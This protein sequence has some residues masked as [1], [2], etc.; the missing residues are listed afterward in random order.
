MLLLKKEEIQQVFSMRDAI[1]ADKNCYKYFSEGK[2]VVPLRTNIPAPA[3]DG[4]FLFMPAYI[5]DM[6]AAAVKV[7]D[8]FPR[9]A[10]K[11][12]PTT[13]G[14]VILID[15][16]TGEVISVMDGTYITALRTGAASG[17]AFDLWGLEDAKI[18]ALIGTGSQAECQLE[19]M[20]A[21]R[22]LE[23]V[24]VSARN[25]EKTKAFV[26]KMNVKFAHYGTKIIAVATSDEAIEHADLVTTVTV[27]EAP[28]FDADKIKKGA[29][30]SCV[31]SYTPVM[32]EMDPKLLNY[33]SKIYFDSK[34]AVLSESGDILKPLEAGTVKEEDF[35][36]DIGEYMLG[37]IP[38]RENEEE[39]IVFKNVGIG[40]LD[41]V[42]AAEI[43]K[44]AVAAGVGLEWK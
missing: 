1:E 19:A 37:Q 28:V 43:Y 12:I 14:Q 31:G 4:A 22:N 39:I 6:K 35:T 32:Q 5:E 44:K 38:G 36:G 7:V 20:L 29:V 25:F 17:A 21:A 40:A 41:L 11:G 13:V 16:T 2:A 26:E 23:E 3:E 24:R 10:K 33:A 42:T 34:D 15:G 8:V 18:G 27:A 30:V 9:N